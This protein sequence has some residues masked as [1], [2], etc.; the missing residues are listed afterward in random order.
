M[1]ALLAAA[2]VANMLSG[3]FL[4]QRKCRVFSLV[5]AGLDC[6]QIPFGTALGVFDFIVLLRDSVRQSYAA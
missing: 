5:V 1:G 6:L 3:V 4:R 2:C